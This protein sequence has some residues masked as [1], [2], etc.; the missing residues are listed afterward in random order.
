MAPG[1]MNSESIPYR[2]RS[3]CRDTEARNMNIAEGIVSNIIWL[4]CK[5]M[6]VMVGKIGGNETEESF[7][8]QTEE[9]HWG[10]RLI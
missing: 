4:V 2:E 5:F 1:S 8:C 3:M 6:D 10:L 9:S 7:E